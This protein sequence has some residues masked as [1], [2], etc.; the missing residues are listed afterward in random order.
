MSQNS[1]ESPPKPPK[2]RKIVKEDVM[3][4]C[5]LVARG[6]TERESL[7]KLE[8]KEDTWHKWKSRHASQFDRTFSN[9]KA[10]RIANLLD[11]MEKHSE[12]S[13]DDGIKADWRC[14]H[15]LLPLADARFREQKQESEQKQPV[16]AIVSSS[17]ASSIFAQLGQQSPPKAICDA[18]DGIVD[19]ESK[20][21]EPSNG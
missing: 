14:T 5:R 12:G 3:A 16:L 10:N 4:V 11:R 21:V 17:I 20:P 8:I 9:I 6:L 15:A 19:V 2:R 13:P 18:R 1:L 7:A